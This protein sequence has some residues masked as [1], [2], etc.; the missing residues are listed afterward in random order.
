M[1][2]VQTEGLRVRIFHKP[3]FDPEIDLALYFFPLWLCRP[4]WP[5]PILFYLVFSRSLYTVL[6]VTNDLVEI[7]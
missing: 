7:L 2:G 4:G 3:R 6:E 1:L 5:F